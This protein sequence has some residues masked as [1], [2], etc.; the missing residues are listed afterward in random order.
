MSLRVW[1]IITAGCSAASADR[2]F[3]GR[4][5][6]DPRLCGVDAGVPSYFVIT[7]AAT[8]LPTTLVALHSMSRKGKSAEDIISWAGKDINPTSRRAGSSD[9]LDQGPPKHPICLQP[10]RPKGRVAF[11]FFFE[12]NPAIFRANHLRAECSPP[13]RTSVSAPPNRRRDCVYPDR[14]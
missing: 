2:M 8:G 6:V 10:E 12:Q 9:A 13:M 7:A 3:E 1:Q 14:N 4:T 11:Y 5:P